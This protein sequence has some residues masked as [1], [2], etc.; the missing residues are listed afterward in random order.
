MLSSAYPPWVPRSSTA[1][2]T[3]RIRA[4]IGLVLALTCLACWGCSSTKSTG[5]TST[6]VDTSPVATSTA[7]STAGAP[8]VSQP[9]LDCAP[10]TTECTAP[11]TVKTLPPLPGSLPV[12][13]TQGPLSVTTKLP[14]GT[15]LCAPGLYSWRI[16][17][18]G[19]IRMAGYVSE[20]TTFDFIITGTTGRFTYQGEVDDATTFAVTEPVRVGTPKLVTL[21]TPG[22]SCIVPHVG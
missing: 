11:A 20:G 3:V 22:G 8:T 12:Q 13:A 4:S 1:S 14:S 6:P 21:H 19:D 10:P 17:D 7:E 9:A 16:A 2:K 5:N 18:G 15:Y